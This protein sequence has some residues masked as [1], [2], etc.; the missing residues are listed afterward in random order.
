MRNQKRKLGQ[1]HLLT[2][3]LLIQG[4][5]AFAETEAPFRVGLNMIRT[6]TTSESSHFDEIDE[7]LSDIS[8]LG[9]GGMRQMQSYDMTWFQL[10]GGS[11][12]LN[13]SSNY[14]FSKSDEVVYNSHGLYPIPTLFWIGTSTA[15]RYF[16]DD[17]PEGGASDSEYCKQ[18]YTPAGDVLKV[19]DN[20]VEADVRDY[21]TFTAQHY[22]SSGIK[23]Y[24]IGNE[25]EFFK[26][27]NILWFDFKWEPAKYADL[28]KLSHEVLKDVD[29]EIQIVMAGLSYNDQYDKDK[30]QEMWEDWFD[31]IL[32]KGAGDYIDVVNFH[33]YGNW[34]DL[35]DHITEVKDLMKKH[36]IEDKPIWMTEVGNSS[37]ELS[38]ERQAEDVYKYLA[39]AF[40]NG[41]EL[42]NWH[43]HISSHDGEGNWGG[44]GLRKATAGRKLSYFAFQKFTEKFG[45]FGKCTAISNG[46]DNLWLYKF[47]GRLKADK[48][49]MPTRYLA[50]TKDGSQ[51]VNLSGSIGLNKRM[52]V[53]S[54]VSSSSGEFTV[55]NQYSS[56]NINVTSTPKIVE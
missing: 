31:K 25:A 6:S 2:L 17:C 47:S 13:S 15:A 30:R 43:T 35:Q 33:F 26:H 48:T 24:E 50:W 3:S 37:S 44:Y 38:E 23:H 11:G 8:K 54:G 5:M 36:D 39:I 29:P 7:V 34:W 45:N 53:T 28:L 49:T 16:G 42:A 27:T 14:E 41:V 40:C 56:R 52:S 1:T 4:S 9:A 46:E 55:N 51:S 18:P 10:Y 19:S 21:L 22:Q 20:D 12:S 32:S